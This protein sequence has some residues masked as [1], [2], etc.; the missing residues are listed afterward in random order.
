[1]T[2]VELAQVY[3]FPKRS[4][5]TFHDWPTEDLMAWV[6]NY[7]RY[8]AE[9]IEAA[10]DRTE[11]TVAYCEHRMNAMLAELDHRKRLARRFKNDPLGPR[12]STA[13]GKQRSSVVD[14]GQELK[15][16]WPI[17]RFMTELMHVQLI[18]A[19]RNRWRCQ[20][21]SPAHQDRTPSMVVYGEDNHVHCF[22]CGAHGDV[23][24]LTA[25]YFGL[26]SFADTV[27]KLA[28]VSSPTLRKEA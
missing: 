18:P 19:G 14:L 27:R 13:G 8:R 15:Q 24:D 22:S 9:S 6:D 2:T 20:C 12:W 1:M 23:L 11:G 21:V 5:E 28:E 3:T 25:M 17:D 10:N 16:L 4:G 26:S 7:Q